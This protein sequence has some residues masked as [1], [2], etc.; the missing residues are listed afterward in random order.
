MVL[1]FLRNRFK[2]AESRTAAVREPMAEYGEAELGGTGDLTVEPVPVTAGET[3]E[4]RYR[5]E[6]AGSSQPVVL[7]L[8]YGYGDWTNVQNVPME[9]L[10]DGSWGAHV[11]VDKDSAL[12]FCF[13]DGERWDNNNGANWV[14]EVHNGFQI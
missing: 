8:G 3:I 11:T 7:H 2:R 6:L 14:Y 13:T 10:P 4:V 12:N 9:R 5:G 1:D